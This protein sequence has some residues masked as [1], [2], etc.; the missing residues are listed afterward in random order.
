VVTDEELVATECGAAVVPGRDASVEVEAGKSSGSG[1]F[2]NCY[3]F[4][5]DLEVQW[6]W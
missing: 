2:G 6:G 3:V 5:C 1:N 4:V